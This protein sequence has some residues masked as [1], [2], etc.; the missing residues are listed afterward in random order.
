MQKGAKKK[1]KEEKNKEGSTE[2]KHKFRKRGKGVFLQHG[3]FSGGA[4]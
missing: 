2:L 3:A 4:N 1:I